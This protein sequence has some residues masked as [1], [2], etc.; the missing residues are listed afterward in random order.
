MQLTTANWA[1][2][3]RSC[4]ERLAL[5]WNH[6]GTRK[7]DFFQGV[8]RA[9]LF[10]SPKGITADC[11]PAALS[12]FRCHHRVP[13]SGADERPHAPACGGPEP[14][15][16]RPG[17]SGSRNHHHM[18]SHNRQFAFAI[19]NTLLLPRVA[20]QSIPKQYLVPAYWWHSIMVRM[21]LRINQG[22]RRQFRGLVSPSLYMSAVQASSNRY[23]N[24]PGIRCHSRCQKTAPDMDASAP[25]SVET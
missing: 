3:A 10:S 9:A 20:G 21:C 13:R 5:E 18:Q 12:D 23:P 22:T 4:C 6:C 8:R 17:E 14:R 24:R 16:A 15:A 19:W 2:R 7:R 11:E 25:W 1:L